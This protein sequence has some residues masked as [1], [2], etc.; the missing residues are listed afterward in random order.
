VLGKYQP[1]HFAVHPA[2]VNGR[3]GYVFTA[4]D[5]VDS[6]LCAEVDEHGTI[7]ALRLIRNPEKLS[8]VRV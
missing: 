2:D 1:G 6:V 4:A 8:R 5:T 3:P 7:T